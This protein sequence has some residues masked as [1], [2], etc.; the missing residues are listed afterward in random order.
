VDVDP[1]VNAFVN[2]KV[3]AI[4]ECDCADGLYFKYYN[5]Y[6][7]PTV[8]PDEDDNEAWGY[9]QCFVKIQQLLNSSW[10]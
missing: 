4:V 1:R 5:P 3:V 10:K 8:S 2:G 6:T 9:I 7:N